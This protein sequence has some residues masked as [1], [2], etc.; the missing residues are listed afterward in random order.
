MENKTLKRGSLRRGM[1]ETRTF[2]SAKASR[3]SEAA[4]C[5]TEPTGAGASPTSGGSRESPG[6]GLEVTGRG[7]RRGG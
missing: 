6:G 4:A 3:Q 1:K 2:P 7:S 5:R